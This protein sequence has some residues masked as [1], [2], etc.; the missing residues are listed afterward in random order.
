MT[1]AAM[2]KGAT[3]KRTGNQ[4]EGDTEKLSFDVD[5]KKEGMPFYFKDLRDN[6]YIFFRAYVD[7]INENISPSWVE[8]NY[9]GRSESAYVYE[10]TGRTLSFNL[11]LFANTQKELH[12]IYRKMDALTGLCYPE[13]AK[14]QYLST[15]NLSSAQQESTTTPSVGKLRMKPPLTKLR[16]GE[17]FGKENKE[18]IGFIDSLTYNIPDE[19][20]WETDSGKR[21]PK[22]I[23]ASINYRVIHNEP[24]SK[25]TTFYGINL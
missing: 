15:I 14:D 10:R 21:V 2:I 13:Y 23:Q 17:L 1:L 6:T 18:L 16:L 11:T 24:P 9:I 8:Q 20:T 25:D 7:G 19:S 22:Y 5:A 12:M 3:L 4:T